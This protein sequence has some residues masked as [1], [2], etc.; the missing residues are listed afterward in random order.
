MEVDVF[1]SWIDECKKVNYDCHEDQPKEDYEDH[2]SD[3]DEHDFGLKED[4]GPKTR[5]KRRENAFSDHLE[6]K[7]EFGH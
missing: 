5:K 2:D 3:L 7:T 1:A 6:V 4:T